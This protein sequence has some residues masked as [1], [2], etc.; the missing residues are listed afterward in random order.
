LA[1]WSTAAASADQGPRPLRLARQGSEV[2][3]AL[4]AAL[5][6]KVGQAS[7]PE[8]AASL[9]ALGSCHPGALQQEELAAAVDQ[10]LAGGMA[11]MDGG[12]WALEA[13]RC[14]ALR[15][16]LMPWPLPSLRLRCPEQA[17]RRCQPPC[18]IPSAA[19]TRLRWRPPAAARPRAAAAAAAAGEELCA[20]LVALAALQLPLPATWEGA[21]LLPPYKLHSLSAR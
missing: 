13:G 14:R 5:A 1:A 19:S 4:A 16:T 2:P 9:K 6:G 12:R 7:L 20:A 17:P 8:L 18:P 15:C 21:V 3:A 11:R 10:H